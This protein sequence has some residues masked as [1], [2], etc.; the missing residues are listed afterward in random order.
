MK[1]VTKEQ[2]TNTLWTI[3]FATDLEC[4][5]DDH[6]VLCDMCKVVL[7]K[8]ALRFKPASEIPESYIWAHKDV[9]AHF[10]DTICPDIVP[11]PTEF[12]VICNLYFDFELWEV[13]QSLATRI[14]NI[15]KEF[16]K[17]AA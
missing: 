4:C 7:N 14:S 8:V 6:D 2:I 5:P 12:E 1:P 10:F 15:A 13:T 16:V 9:E 3:L 11:S 17:T